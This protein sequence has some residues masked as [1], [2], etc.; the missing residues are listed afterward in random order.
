MHNDYPWDK[1]P[2]DSDEPK[3]NFTTRLRLED[4]IRNYWEIYVHNRARIAEL[5]GSKATITKPDFN[6]SG[7]SIEDLREWLAI[8][9]NNADIAVQ[10]RAQIENEKP[11]RK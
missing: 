5:T 4:E 7:G 9:K 3:V 6:L 8:A 11:R 1:G 10:H 2:E